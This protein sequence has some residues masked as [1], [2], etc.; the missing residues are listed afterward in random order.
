M[1]SCVSSAVP[2]GSA[3]P[4]AAALE[5]YTTRSTPARRHSSI[6]S[7]VPPT[8]TRKTRSVSAGRTEVTPAQYNVLRIL[9]NARSAGAAG[10]ACGEIAERLVRHDPDVTRLLDRLEARGLVSRSRDTADRRVIVAGITDAGV[11]TLDRIGEAVATLHAEQFRRI[12]RQELRTLVSLLEKVR[13]E[14]EP[15]RRS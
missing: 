3:G 12:G 15:P 4:T 8:F 9:H 14:G 10:L 1:K 5:V 13:G 11:A 6:T 2:P 7:F